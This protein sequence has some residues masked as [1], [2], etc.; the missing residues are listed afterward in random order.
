MPL[1]YLLACLLLPF[2]ARAQTFPALTERVVDQAGLLDAASETA[3]VDKLA[4]HESATSNQV[5]VVT[6]NSLQGYDIADYGYRLGREWGIGTA[7]RNNG[8]LLIVA[9]NERKVRIEVGYGLEGAL[10]DA[11]ASVIIQREILPAFRNG[12]MAAG[13]TAGTDAIL[14]AVEGEYTAP[15]APSGRNADPIS[16]QIGNFIPLIFLAMVAIPEILKRFGLTRA[17]HSAFPAGFAGLM[18]TLI[19]GSLLIGLAIAVIAFLFMIFF[20]GDPG[21]GGG[22][23]RRRR[24]GPGGVIIGG[25]GG[26]FGGGFGGGGGSFGGGGASGSW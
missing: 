23:S 6:L 3:L 7:E 19:S 13:I 21:G 9:P 24:R 15:A 12:D 20:G 26:G 18:G 8:V 5:V 25:G 14:Q 4:A 17:A 11:L 22:G 2:A 10:P 16:R 1:A